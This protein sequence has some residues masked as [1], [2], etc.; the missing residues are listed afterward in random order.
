MLVLSFN[1]NSNK[2]ITMDKSLT[3]RTQVFLSSVLETIWAIG[4]GSVGG[5]LST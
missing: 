3:A 4:G 2:E 5:Y 1:D